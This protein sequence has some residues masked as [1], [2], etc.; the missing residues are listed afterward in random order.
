MERVQCRTSLRDPH[1]T[2]LKLLDSTTNSLN[3]QI[4]ADICDE[5]EK[6]NYGRNVIDITRLVITT[7]DLSLCPQNSSIN[8]CTN[9][10]TEKTSLTISGLA[11][12]NCYDVTHT[13]TLKWNIPSYASPIEF[14]TGM[15]NPNAEQSYD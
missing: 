8:N 7:W 5:G 12:S 13:A 11:E 15:F 14:C 6:T 9:V 2:E 3:L 1:K 10:T 4:E